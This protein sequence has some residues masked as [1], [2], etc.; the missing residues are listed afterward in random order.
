MRPGS[1]PGSLA[2]QANPPFQR[3]VSNHS[4]R[5][6]GRQARPS[7]RVLR[8]RSAWQVGIVAAALLAGCAFPSLGPAETASAEQELLGRLDA[9]MLFVARHSYTGIHI[10]D[11]FYK[12]PPGGGGIYVL[13][14]PAAPRDDWRIR[15]VI[16]PTSAETL[17][18]GVYSDPALS[19]DAQRLL[20]CFKGDPNGDT[21]IYEI[22]IDGRGLRR[23]TDPS[24]HADDNRGSFAGQ[25][26]ISP[27]YLPDG[28]IVFLS[29]R[30]S[31][32]VPCFNSG[33]AILH[34]MQADGSDIHPISVNNVNEFDPTVMPD[35]RLL[36]GRWEYVDKNALTIQSLWTVNPDGTQETALYANNMVFPEAILDARCVPD[37]H[38]IVGTLAK[39]NGTPRGSIAWIDPRIGK[40]SPD[41]IINLEH[42]DDPTYDRGDSCEPWPLGDQAVLFSGRPPGETRNVIEILDRAGRRIVVHSDPDICLHSPM[43]VKPSPVPA[44]LPD[45]IDRR[46]D[47]RSVLR[48]GHLSRT[49]WRRTGR[50]QMAPRAGRDLANQSPTGGQESLQPDLS[51]QLRVSLQY[52]ELP[53]R[54]ARRGGWIGMLRSACGPRC[55]YRLW[56]K[57]A[58]WCRACGRSSKRRRAPH[59]PASDVTSTSSRPA[60]PRR[61]FELHGTHARPTATRVVGNGLPG[62]HSA[63]PADS[64][65]ALH[66]LSR[67][68]AGHRRRYRSLRRLD[69]TLQY[70][71][72]KSHESLRDAIDRSL[73]RGNRLHEWDGDV[74]GPTISPAESRVR[75]RAVGGSAGRRTWRPV[76]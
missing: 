20:F 65:S 8:S 41:A 27:E 69:G 37:S 40:N 74:V 33:V 3:V 39:H 55:T 58:D 10:Y 32:L 48:P 2:K 38:L 75:S 61:T 68:R 43:L 66:V 53:G 63:S 4:A 12:W 6:F 54:R 1:G 17:G 70:Q 7:Q 13:E 11:V 51:G 56:T 57:M 47:H 30:P 28:R 72:R 49:R 52:Q 73:D 45:T 23:I 62:L 5:P 60:R 21:S 71:L 64:G 31:G 14:N 26:N 25:H 50:D 22:G 59:D 76:T 36:F 19:P 16:D 29:T 34:V 67:W 35:G 42:P 9:P 44:A 24:A 18:V 46:A 15:P